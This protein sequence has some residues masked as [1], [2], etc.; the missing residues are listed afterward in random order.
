MA[1]S[2]S[3]EA[4]GDLLS[5]SEQRKDGKR[6]GDSVDEQQSRRSFTSSRQSSEYYGGESTVKFIWQVCVTLQ[7]LSI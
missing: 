7:A 5:V 4:S 2:S 6:H 1:A 3:G